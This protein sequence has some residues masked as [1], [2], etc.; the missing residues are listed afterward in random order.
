MTNGN[1][2]RRDTTVFRKIL[3]LIVMTSIVPALVGRTRVPAWKGDRARTSGNSA[4]RAAPFEPALVSARAPERTF[5]R[6]P[7]RTLVTR[8]LAARAWHRRRPAHPVRW[9]SGSAEAALEPLRFPTS[10]HLDPLQPTPDPPLLAGMC[11][12]KT[13]TPQETAGGSVVTRPAAPGTPWCQA[14]CAP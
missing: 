12:R 3:I 1:L 6:R 8:A 9:G 7:R 11:R 13:P 2:E 14:C 10:S 5:R 4:C